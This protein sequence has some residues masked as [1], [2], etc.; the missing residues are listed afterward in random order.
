MITACIL[1]GADTTRHIIAALSPYG[2]SRGHVALML[3]RGRRPFWR[4][5]GEGRYALTEHH[6]LLAQAAE[7]E[8]TRTT[9]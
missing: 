7:E 4:K 9:M 8:A 1:N 5:D 6:P 3:T 2:Y